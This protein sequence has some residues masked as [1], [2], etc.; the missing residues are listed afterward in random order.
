[1][2]IR[3]IGTHKRCLTKGKATN[4]GH[5]SR[6][7]LDYRFPCVWRRPCELNSTLRSA[8]LLFPVI[9]LHLAML[10][11]LGAAALL[12]PICSD[13]RRFVSFRGV[14]L[15]NGR[16]L[17]L[18][19]L[20]VAPFRDPR[21]PPYNG[22]RAQVVGIGRRAHLAAAGPG[23]I[24]LVVRRVGAVERPMARPKVRL[25][26]VQLAVVIIKLGAFFSLP[27]VT[28]SRRGGDNSRRSESK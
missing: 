12:C 8:A 9:P 6:Q 3:D 22:W 4:K 11:I 19:L 26:V 10:A 20:L 16:G 23:S 18:F 14:K 28:A 27:L 17:R 15:V 24:G 21:L 25:K 2:A 7:N 13:R 1:V 5:S